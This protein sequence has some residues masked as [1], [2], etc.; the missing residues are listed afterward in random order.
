[1]FADTRGRHYPA[2]VDCRN[3]GSELLV[4]PA[5]P[6][7]PLDPH[8]PHQRDR[9]H[10]TAA[11]RRRVKLIGRLPGERYAL[12]QPWAV[13]D[14]TAAGRRGPTH[15]SA[16]TRCLQMIRRDLGLTPPTQ[17]ANH[18]DDND[19]T[20]AATYHDHQQRRPVPLLHRP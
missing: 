15:A 17:P 18:H 14:R 10:A 7:G 13:L 3:D 6:A 8:P 2:A 16:P 5:R 11:S 1:M 4:A 12:V 19:D 9:A 20:T